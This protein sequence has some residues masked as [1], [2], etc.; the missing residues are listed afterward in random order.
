MRSC[1]AAA[2]A[3]LASALLAAGCLGAH[4][5]AKP[6]L[7]RFNVPAGEAEVALKKFATQSG[8]QILFPTEIVEAVQTNAVKGRHTMTEALDLLLAGTPLFA[9][10][11]ESTGAIAIGRLTVPARVIELPLFV[12]KE[13]PHAPWRYAQMPGLEL[14]SRCPDEVT[15][16]LLE[17]NQRLLELLELIVPADLQVSSV[18]PALFVLYAAESQ[19]T[20]A[21][22]LLNELEKQDE[23]QTV[24]GAAASRAP[25]QVRVMRNY[26]FWDQDSLAIFFILTDSDFD[27]GRLALTSGYV[28]YRLEARTPTLPRWFIEG[29]VELYHSVTL[30][31]ATMDLGTVNT[32]DENAAVFW[33]MPWLSD[34]ETQAIKKSPRQKRDLPNLAALFEARPPEELDSAEGRLWRAQAA[35]LVRWALDNDKSGR[36]A[37]LWKFVA[38]ASKAPVTEALFNDCLNLDYTEAGRQLEAY[39]PLAVEHGFKLSP[40]KSAPLPDVK[41]RDATTPEI[42]RIKGDLERL[43]ISYVEAL[44]PQLAGYYAAQA[45]RTLRAAYDKGDRDPRL[46]AVLGLTE[47]AAGNDAA[48]R[49][50]LV[51]AVAQGVKRPRAYYELARIDFEAMRAKDPTGRL[52]P[53]EAGLILKPLAAGR[54]FSPPLAEAYELIAEV[55]LRCD[56]RLSAK[57]LAVFDEGIGFFPRRERLIYYAA[58]LHATQ[59]FG[60][61]A[62][63]LI[64]R[65]LAVANEPEEQER[66]EKLQAALH[67][68]KK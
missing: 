2:K 25:W 5:A 56:G 9:R 49:P 65:G 36:R 6:S 52:T 1:C 4:A 34:A 17:Q 59:G 38:L 53:A 35:L 26:R 10:E 44:Y 43:E 23:H 67:E 57:Q 47:C 28:R 48:A 61:S 18:N 63:A 7:H 15:R 20:I 27:K 60:E 42:A 16:K 32:T 8:R 66:F 24:T 50:F 68:Q 40:A 11:D 22:E 12:V 64:E 3:L 29:V 46:L 58:L 21:R 14:I 51:E 33:P 45:R 31:P 19:P 13:S 62:L 54:R 37:A 41:L 55:W 30:E 39:L